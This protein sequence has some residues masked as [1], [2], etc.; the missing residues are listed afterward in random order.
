[1]SRKLKYTFDDYYNNPSGKGSAVAPGINKKYLYQNY[2][3]NLLS[4]RYNLKSRR[5]VLCRF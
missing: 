3:E 4:L 2:E 5:A 1:M